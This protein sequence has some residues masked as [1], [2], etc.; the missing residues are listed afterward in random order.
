MSPLAVA[1]VV[2]AP[3]VVVGVVVV[4][5]KHVPDVAVIN[6]LSVIAVHSAAVATHEP[7]TD[8]GLIAV[9]QMQFMFCV[10][11]SLMHSC[12]RRNTVSAHSLTLTLT[13]IALYQSLTHQRT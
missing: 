11:D 8:C 3:V 6:C 5:T 10:S 4:G 2:V 7:S 13:R 12:T 9:H 1:A